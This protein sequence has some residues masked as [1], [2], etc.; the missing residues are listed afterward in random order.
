MGYKAS[1]EEIFAILNDLD[2]DNSGDIE[3]YEFLSAYERR[4]TA[5]EADADDEDLSTC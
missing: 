3:F 4:M 2:D 1:E 5:R